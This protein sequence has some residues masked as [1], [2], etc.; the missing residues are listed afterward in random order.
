M[1][2]EGLIAAI[3]AMS[4]RLPVEQ[5]RI[6]VEAAAA[7]STP[8][9]PIELLLGVAYVESRFDQRALSRLECETPDACVRK[10]GVWLR[11]TKPPKARRSWYCGP[12]Q[13]GGY[14]SWDECQ[15]MRTDVAYGYTSGV[16]E[17]TTWMNDP[18]CSK[19]SDNDRIRCALA[20]HNGGY[21]SAKN[22]HKSKYVVWVFLARDRIV[23]FAEFAE[24][25]AT[26]PQT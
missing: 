22:F 14:V 25:R 9:L 26:K 17:L 18:H 12:M 11:A 23:R 2:L 5:A 6:H 7:A 13:T 15:R 21:A 19:L 16:K 8:D 3:V 20:G 10:T 1:S 24:T 4:F